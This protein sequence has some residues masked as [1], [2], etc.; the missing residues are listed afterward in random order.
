MMTLLGVL[1]EGLLANNSA[2]VMWAA[3]ALT[4]LRL[5]F[6][7]TSLNVPE[8]LLNGLYLWFVNDTGDRLDSTASKSSGLITALK[9]LHTT[10][11]AAPSI[12]DFISAYSDE[13]LFYI[14]SKVLRQHIIQQ[15]TDKT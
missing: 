4:S 11:S 10:P 8:H 7:N 3:T 2:T 9:A 13:G 14:V 5:S 15:A 12:V 6:N 1:S